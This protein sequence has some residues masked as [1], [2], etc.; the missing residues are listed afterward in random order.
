MNEFM[1]HGTFE[2]LIH[3][4]ELSVVVGIGVTIYITKKYSPKMNR[5]LEKKLDDEV[6]D[7]SE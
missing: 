1:D 2:M 3:L 4:L 5:E 7:L 6:L